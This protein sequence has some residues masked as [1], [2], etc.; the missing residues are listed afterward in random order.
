MGLGHKVL[1]A[2]APGTGDQHSK[3]EGDATDETC[4]GN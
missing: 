1:G 2:A 3:R 4:K